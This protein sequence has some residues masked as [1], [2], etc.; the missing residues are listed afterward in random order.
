MLRKVNEK[1]KNEE[2]SCANSAK[3]K[4]KNKSQDKVANLDEPEPGNSIT[5]RVL[6][7]DNFVDMDISGINNEFPSEE[8]E[9]D[10]TEVNLNS[11]E[12]S[13]SQN[14]NASFPPP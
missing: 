6:E 13:G 3:I 8:D 10:I 12:M 1:R 11:Q 14:N 2:E 7:D 9:E 5:A 4:R